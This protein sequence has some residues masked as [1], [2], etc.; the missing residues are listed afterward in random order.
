MRLHR[1]LYALPL[2]LA[3]C[4][5]GPGVQPGQTAAQAEQQFGRAPTARY[6]LASGGTRL[7]YAGGPYGRETWMVDLDAGGHV[8]GV[9]QA[10]GEAQFAAFQARGPGLP[11]E[12]LLALLG[13]PGERRGVWRG[14]E[15]WA[16]RYPT[17]DCL[18]F[19]VTLDREGRVK[20][21]GYGPDPRCDAPNDRN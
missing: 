1:A 7:E 18:W 9:T 4:A 11:R 8:A 2:L 17:N 16:W 21:S 13:T 6:A 5:G 10:L 12:D 3:A 20:D 14:G 19:Q 15:I